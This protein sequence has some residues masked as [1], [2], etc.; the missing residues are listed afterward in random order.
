M[1]KRFLVSKLAISVLIMTAFLLTATLSASAADSV[2]RQMTVFGVGE[3]YTTPD[4]AQVTLGV[5]IQHSDLQEAKRQND[6][7]V[8]KVFELAQQLKIKQENVKADYIW[9]MPRY[10]GKEVAYTVQRNVTFVLTDLSIFDQFIQLAVESGANRVTQVEFLSSDLNA[11]KQEA[12]ILALK[13]A[14]EKAQLMAAELGLKVGKAITVTDDSNW[15]PVYNAKYATAEAFNNRGNLS[16]SNTPI[17]SIQISARITVVFE[18]LI[19]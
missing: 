3:V 8:K 13:N 10:D 17:G 1:T 4:R 2:I 11:K 6:E 18:L 9:I 16:G 19:D 12:M 5:E 15:S 7:A 14:K